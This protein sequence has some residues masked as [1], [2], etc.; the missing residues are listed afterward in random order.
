VIKATKTYGF[1]WNFQ[2]C[3]LETQ[4]DEILGTPNSGGSGPCVSMCPYV[5]S[6]H[7]TH[8]DQIQ[9]NNSSKRGEDLGSFL[10]CR[11][12]EGSG[13]TFVLGFVNHCWP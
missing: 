3:Y 1:W 12:G 11:M 4:C 13:G 10:P 8:S 9:H 7:L 5:W 6:Y 2:G